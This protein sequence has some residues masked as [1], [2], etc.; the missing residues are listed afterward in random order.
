MRPILIAVLI[1]S[2][3]LLNAQQASNSGVIDRIEKS[4]V[5]PKNDASVP[6][7]NSFW[8]FFGPYGEATAPALRLRQA[9]RARALVR[10]G[11]LYLSLYDAIALAIENN[12]DVEVA[13]YQLSISGTEVLRAS[14]GGTLRG[15][16]YSVSESPTGVGG[17]G[18]PLLNSAASSVT[19][20]T[21]TVNDLTSLNVLS[22]TQTNLSEQGTAGYAAGPQCRHSNPRWLARALIFSAQ[23]PV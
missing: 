8:K 2:Q 11:K 18:S 3:V 16:D 20:T 12:L 6:F 7:K 22:E 13:R 17:P 15:V 23:V 5:R 19:P 21:P 1:Y 9:E 14:G 4:A 10:D